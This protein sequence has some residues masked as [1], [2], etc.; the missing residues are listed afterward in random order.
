MKTLQA[1][2][3]FVRTVDAG[4]LSAAGRSLGLSPA[5]VS[6]LVG[7][8]EDELG[9]QLLNR[10]S[11]SLSLTVPGKEYFLRASKILQDLDE[12]HRMVGEFKATPKGLLKIH[13][14]TLVGIHLIAPSLKQ[15]SDE[16]PDVVVE[17]TLSENAANL[18][19]DGYDLDIR[20]GELQDSMEVVSKL[21]SSER[22]LVASPEYLATHQSITQPMDI[23]RHNCLIYKTNVDFSQWKFAKGE[24]VETVIADGNLHTN[25]GEVLLRAV[26][27]G[28]GLAVLTDWTV[29][30]A[31]Q[32]GKLQIVLPE[33][34]V[35][36]SSF[37]TGIYAVYHQ[38]KRTPPNIKRFIDHLQRTVRQ[39][40]GSSTR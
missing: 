27:G 7:S 40:V 28:Q 6:R 23:A 38:K 21:I 35:T 10:S 24:R 33:Y 39:Q 19:Q 15:F 32:A 36:Q 26:L 17:L 34:R 3:A 5:S 18:L 8:L 31:I 13:S 30:P 16:N 1:I 20:I 22:I 12:A 37:E 9:V 2:S 29:F 25:N 14:R 4:S 11:R